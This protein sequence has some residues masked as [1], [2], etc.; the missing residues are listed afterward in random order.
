MKHFN[1]HMNDDDQLCIIH[2]EPPRFSARLHIGALPEDI[3]GPKYSSYGSGADNI[4]FSH[5]TYYDPP[6][7]PHEVAVV[8]EEAALHTEEE[9]VIK[10]F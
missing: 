3:K 6:S 10:G 7:E 5:L 9:C 1:I 8:M 2:L 4:H